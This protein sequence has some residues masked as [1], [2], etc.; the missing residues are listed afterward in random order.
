MRTYEDSRNLQPGNR[1]R[2]HWEQLVED[3]GIPKRK[4]W[5]KQRIYAHPTSTESKEGRKVTTF[6]GWIDGHRAVIG[7][8]TY[9][10]IS[11][12]SAEFAAKSWQRRSRR[13]LRMTG[14]G[15]TTMGDRVNVPVKWRTGCAELHIDARVSDPKHLSAGVDFL[16]GTRIQHSL[17][18]KID[19]G[20]DSLEIGETPSK[21]GIV[22][23]L[24]KPATIRRRVNSRGLRV[25]DLAS[26]SASPILV[27][28]DLGWSIDKT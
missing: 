3:T 1:F 16:V 19:Q 6:V 15:S 5:A 7:A 20:N 21:R 28:R 17:E 11:M 18:M 23:D 24:E 25:L 10:E 4:G 13:P 9:A 26:G 8:D 27:L 22:I 14:L 12:V 2:K